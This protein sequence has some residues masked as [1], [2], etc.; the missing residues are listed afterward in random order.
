MIYPASIEEK[1]GFDVIRNQLITYCKSDLG[2][3]L[4]A[5]LSFLTKIE[6]IE[7]LLIQV[8][9]FQQ[10]LA[11]GKIPSLTSFTNIKTSLEKS[12]LEGNW[13][14]ARELFDIYTSAS[15]AS[16][17][18]AFII[19]VSAE[20]PSLLYFVTETGN[21][22]EL[23]KRLLLMLMELN[24]NDQSGKVLGPSTFF[25]LHFLRQNYLIL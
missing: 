3:N 15:S 14:S 24:G 25:L 17:M 23:E 21:L 13:L 9:D 4:V 5:E 7:K 10:L 12:R 19:E 1:L 6:E 8:D 18:M 16:A 22:A 11:Q 2:K 20:Y